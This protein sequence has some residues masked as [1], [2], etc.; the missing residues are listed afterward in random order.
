MVEHER[1]G[2][3]DLTTWTLSRIAMILPAVIVVVMSIEVV[4]RYIFASATLWANELSLWLAGSAYLLASLYSMQQR[5]HIRITLIY[6]SVPKWLKHVFDLIS[7]ALLL[8]FVFA[9]FWGGYGEAM[10]KL[11]RWERFG[12]A[13]DPPIP[14]TMKP[15]ILTAFVLIAIQA[16][17]NL[18]HDWGKVDAAHDLLD[19]ADIDVETL[20]KIQAEIEASHHS[21]HA[22]GPDARTTKQDRAT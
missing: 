15:L 19:E 9:L 6:D 10:A 12:T 2:L 4:S 14:A 18:I 11:M 22:A 3:V 8:T 5:S 13:W 20:R 21:E 16:V 1:T 17:S 7:L